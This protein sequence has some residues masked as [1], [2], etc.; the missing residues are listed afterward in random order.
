MAVVISS[1]TASSN[2]ITINSSTT[3]TPVFSGGTGVILS[4]PTGGNAVQ[5]ATPVNSGVAVVVTPLL[6]YTYALM[7]TADDGSES[8][9]MKLN[10]AVTIPAA[11]KLSVSTGAGV[12]HPGTNDY[13]CNAAVYFIRVMVSPESMSDHIAHTNENTIKYQ[14]I[15]NNNGEDPLGV[16]GITSLNTILAKFG[17]IWS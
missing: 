2:T 4:G 5:T 16:I 14:I 17:L 8:K 1:F 7:V 3:L 12:I 9:T 6:P 15:I 11:R 13:Y 10:I